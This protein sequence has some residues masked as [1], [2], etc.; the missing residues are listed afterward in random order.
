MVQLFEHDLFN[1]CS[2]NMW[3]LENLELVEQIQDIWNI[4][5]AK[6]GKE[7]IL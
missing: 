2:K 6:L 3:N 7:M 4:T 5:L 1:N